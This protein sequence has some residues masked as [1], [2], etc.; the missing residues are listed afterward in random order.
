MAAQPIT[1]T[2]SI[3]CSAQLCTGTVASFSLTAV[4]TNASSIFWSKSAGADGSFSTTTGSPTVY[5]PGPNDRIKGVTITLAAT[6]AGGCCKRVTIKLNP[7]PCGAPYYTYTQGYYS[8]SGSACTPLNG[9]VKGAGALI[10]LSLDNMDGV[11]GNSLGKLYLGR[12]GASFTAN[13]S[14][15][16]KLVAILPGGGTATRLL[17]DH[18]LSVFT[19]YPPLNNGKIRNILLSQTIALT[20]NKFIPGNSLKNF[21]LKA[22]HLTTITRINSSCTAGPASCA[23]GGKLSSLKITSSATLMS[24]LNNQTVDSLLRMASKALGGILPAGVGYSDISGAVDV[25]N[26][27]FDEGRHFIGYYSTAQSCG[28][29]VLIVKPINPEY[30]KVGTEIEVEELTVTA[31][32]NPFMDR[33]KFN[34]VSPVSGNASLD[35]YNMLGQKVANVYRG[36]LQAGRGQVI[37][38]NVTGVKETLI[39]SLR[40]GDKQVNGKVIHLK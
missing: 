2:A 7:V 21:I 8:G 32:P 37:E 36:Y 29:P 27:S 13:Y 40:V 26:K 19:S 1:P 35:V 39:Y 18:N 17:V 16:S 4:T 30:S 24:L 11:I 9:S 12:S 33:V 28:A 20:L 38:Y 22:G 31:Y 23:N 14:D 6:S 3:T 5:T 15:A 10:Q 25:I 34:I